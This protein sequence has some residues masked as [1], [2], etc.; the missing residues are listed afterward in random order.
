MDAVDGMGY[1][2]P[3][4]IQEATI[5]IIN[6]GKDVIACA[7]TGTGKTAAYLLPLLNRM[8]INDELGKGIKV[9]VIVPTRELAMQID[10]QLQ[11]MAY[12]AGISS[13]TIYGGGDAV[14][15]DIQKKA[16]L[17]GADIIIATPGRF[18]SH[19]SLGYVDLS[20]V[21]YL[22]LDEADKMLD[23][24]F[25]DDIMKI[26]SNI[27]SERQT[28]LLSAT[29]PDRIRGLAKK[30][31]NDPQEI[32]IAVSKPAE[33]ILQAAYMAEDDQKVPLIMSLLQ[34][35]EL[36]SVVIFCST[37]K[38][39][40]TLEKELKKIGLAARAIHSD[41]EQAEREEA[42]REFKNRKFQ[43]MVATDILSRGID[44]DAIDLVM[45]YNVP[46]DAEDYI[47]RIGRT[48]RADAE[49]VAITLVSRHDRFKFQRIERFLQKEIFRI[50]LP[51]GV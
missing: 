6:A 11:G 45:N 7:Q 21:S 20:A 46:S 44:I 39:T 10:Q 30:I 12:F 42:M 48:A 8:M 5:P 14:G 31:M 43:I 49:G 15:W 51:E 25:Y 23:M 41:L 3:T 16:I 1:R 9:L 19:I 33:G 18:I 37:K 40:R 13:I 27:P 34:G 32:A 26:I 36:Q 38:D 17:H 29:M 28:L 4:P 50:P 22:V 47:H 35:K 2:Q 24:G